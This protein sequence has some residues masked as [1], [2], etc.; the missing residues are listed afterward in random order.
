MSVSTKAKAQDEQTLTQENASGEG[1]QQE[2]EG[3]HVRIKR[4]NI[5]LS[6]PKWVV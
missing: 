4:H 5:R 2:D 3:R 1:R 6:G